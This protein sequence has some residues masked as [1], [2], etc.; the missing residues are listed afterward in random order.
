MVTGEGSIDPKPSRK[1]CLQSRRPH[2]GGVPV[3]ALGGWPDV[4]GYPP[5]FAALFRHLRPER[6]REG[7]CA[8]RE[9]LLAAE[10]IGKA[11]RVLPPH[12]S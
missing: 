2:T 11:G 6:L 3:I 4:L 12:G 8:A 7:D 1:A 10:Q 9:N 5:E